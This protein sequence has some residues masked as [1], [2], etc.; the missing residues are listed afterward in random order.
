MKQFSVICV[1]PQDWYVDLPTNRQQVM[2]R[3]G[4]RGHEVVFVE[5]GAF[6]LRHPREL[7]R[8]PGRTLRRLLAT[9]P[10]APGVHLCKA[11]TVVPWGKRFRFASRANFWLTAQR[12][13]CL[14]RRLPQPVVLWIY[15]PCAA[16]MVGSCGEVFAVY[17]CVDDYGE[18]YGAQYGRD[19][20]R[21]AL[22]AAADVEA[23]RR[24]RI[25]FTTTTPLL[26]RHGRNNE[27]TYLV[28]NVGDYTHFAPAADRSLAAA[29]VGDLPRPVI[30]FAGN[31]QIGKVDFEL[32]EHLARAKPEWSVVLIGP[33]RAD[34]REAVARL[35]RLSN[36][37]VLGWKPYTEL[38]RYYAAFD[39]GLCPY[40]WSA[41]MQSGFPLKLY[42]YL[43]VGMPVV[44]SGNPDLAGKEPDVVLARGAEEFV[45]AIEGVLGRV[46]REDRERRRSLAAHNT[47]ET[48][49]ERLLEVVSAELGA[50]E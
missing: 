25:V 50:E 13:K 39:V 34:T 43:A 17:D 4:A 49:T 24:S 31:L 18:Q 35:A 23:A 7:V 11:L 26:E 27:R 42:D 46:S 44:A 33:V 6:L 28:P 30:G 3:V 2:R 19:A 12:L 48:R 1:S 15:D 45:G 10:V 37:H 16:A 8:N 20:R 29:D 22:V 38:P 41:A 5:S 32:L 21:Q 40:V 36:V 47:W 9:E 14:A